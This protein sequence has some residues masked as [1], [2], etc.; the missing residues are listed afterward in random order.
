MAFSVSDLF[1]NFCKDIR[2]SEDDNEKII[3]RYH[4]I[5]K[6]I[7]I[8]YYNSNSDTNHSLYIGSYG[9]DTE[10]LTSD[11]DILVE[12]PYSVYQQYNAIQHR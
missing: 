9:R 10:I 2:I 4:Q 6:R 5:T 11:I 1:E 3:N 7:N 8:D 12:L